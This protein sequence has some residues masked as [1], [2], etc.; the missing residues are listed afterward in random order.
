MNVVIYMHW[1]TENKRIYLK[2]PKK[3]HSAAASVC[4][5]WFRCERCKCGNSILFFWSLISGPPLIGNGEKSS[6][7]QLIQFHYLCWIMRCSLDA[8]CKNICCVAILWCVHQ[9]VASGFPIH[10]SC[11]YVVRSPSKPPNIRLCSS[12]DEMAVSIM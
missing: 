12:I 3:L 9:L 11:H 7:I 8:K 6:I 1:S 2:L 10:H 5:W 4:V